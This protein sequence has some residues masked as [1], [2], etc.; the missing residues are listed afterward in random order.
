MWLP[1]PGSSI[2]RRSSGWSPAPI[3]RVWAK[4]HGFD[5]VAGWNPGV[6][7]AVMESGNTTT[8]GA[9]RQLDIVDGGVFRETLLAHSDLDHFYSYDILGS[10]LPVTGYRST[11]RFLEI[12]AGEQTLSIWEGRFDAAPDAVE[13]LA[14]PVGDEIY[15]NG[16]KGLNETMGREAR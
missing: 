12:A 2:W 4:V 10:P 3:A 7:K 16:L 9:V 8:V 1:S 14:Q 11:H 13:A 15:L 6:V 5:S